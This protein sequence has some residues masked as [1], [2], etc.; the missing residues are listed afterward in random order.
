MNGMKVFIVEDDNWY[1]EFLKHHIAVDEDY[2]IS[3]FK[4]GKEL[5]ENLH[6]EPHIITLDYSLPD[7]TGEELLQK[8]CYRLPNTKII[9][10][11]GQEDVSTAI[12]LIHEGAYDYIVKNKDAAKRLWTV[13]RNIKENKQLHDHLN[14]LKKEVEQK[15]DFSNIIKGDSPEI[16]RVFEIMSKATK[17]DI[18][19]SVTGETG[20]GKELI[21]KAIHH[22]SNRKDKK[23]VPINVAAIP[24]ELIESELFGHEKGAFTGADNRRI[25][26]FEEADK[27]TLF[28]D[29]IGELELSLQAK[30]LRVIQESEVVRVG[31]NTPVKINV[32]IITATHKNLAEEVKK[33]TFREDLYYRI[34][35]LPVKL[36]PLRDRKSDILPLAKYFLEDYT[37]RNNISSMKISADAREKL[38]KY[39]YPG[40]I[41]E[42]KSIIELACVM[43]DEKE[44]FPDDISFHSLAPGQDLLSEELTL[45]QFNIKILQ[46]YIKKYDNNISRV[47]KKLDIGRS[48]V[49]QML[50]EAEQIGM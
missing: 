30:L 25:G 33:G 32:R 21:A 50:K 36:P 45:R 8:I 27:G 38:L 29:E 31:S 22:N 5:L 42:L 46:E 14:Y 3:I 34:I 1:A 4:S 35:G 23:F 9:M 10:V 6:L 19:V 26:K 44:I 20:T 39:N 12:D 37:K 7:T 11:S 18:N 41:R 40:N 49:Y 43:S 24:S 48:T 2:V 28:L 47:A 17:S 16:K 15:Y 13:L